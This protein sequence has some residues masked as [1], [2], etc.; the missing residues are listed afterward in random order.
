[1]SIYRGAGGSGDAVADSS[2]EALLI[3]ELVVEAQADADAASAS[4][5]AAAGSAS[6][7]STA[8]TNAAA[9]AASIDVSLFAQ[10]ANNLSDLT[11]ASTA[12]TNLGLGS[13]ATQA[14]SSIS[15]TGGSITGI[16]DLAVADGGTGVSTLTGIVKGNGTSAFTAATTGTDFVAP[17]T[18]TTFT[19]LQTFAGTSSNADLKTSNILETATISATAATGTIAYDITTQS[20][21]YYTSNASGDW[22]VNFRGSSGTSLNTIMSTG[23]SLSAT[24]L[25]TNG[26]TAYRNT[27]VQVDGSSVTP[28]WQGGSAPTSGNTNSID[29]YTYVIFETG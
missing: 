28:K 1:M 6:T 5:T 19:A 25:V 21:L 26:G 29:V 18:A 15:I 2:S 16:T 14:S 20:V 11:S 9:S 10:K 3:R 4:A 22:T 27:V 13:I 7:A 17:G 8:A 23:E 12:R 24:F